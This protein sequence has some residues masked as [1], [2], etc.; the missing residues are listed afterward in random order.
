MNLTAARTVTKLTLLEQLNIPKINLHVKPYDEASPP[1][2]I[3]TG[4][5][6]VK[7]ISLALQ[8]IQTFPNK[9]ILQ[10]SLIIYGIIIFKINN[11]FQ[12]KYCQWYT[13][14]ELEN[15]KAEPQFLI[16][17]NREEFNDMSRHGEFL[18]IQEQLGN[19]YGFRSYFIYTDLYRTVSQL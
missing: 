5:F 2:I 17:A 9:V 16:F 11:L 7:K 12:V 19:S 3:L 8:I 10:L 18:A 14:K 4:P 6:A 15:D 13:T 1:L